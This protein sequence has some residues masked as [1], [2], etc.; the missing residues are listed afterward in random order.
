MIIVFLYR[1]IVGSV[2]EGLRMKSLDMDILYFMI[3]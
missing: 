2:K 1:R 3:D